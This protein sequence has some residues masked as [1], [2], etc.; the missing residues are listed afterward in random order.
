MDIGSYPIRFPAQASRSSPRP[1]S[2][3][4]HLESQ[5]PP[6]ICCH[7]RPI[8]PLNGFSLGSFHTLLPKKPSLTCCCNGT[9]TLAGTSSL[10]SSYL[11]PHTTRSSATPPQP[12]TKCRIKAQQVITA[13][14]PENADIKLIGTKSPVVTCYFNTNREATERRTPATPPTCE[15]PTRFRPN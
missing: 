4:I 1:H 15:S 9:G 11:P 6:C 13:G 3:I 12:T 10:L 2:L 5:G 8:T 14:R 7:I